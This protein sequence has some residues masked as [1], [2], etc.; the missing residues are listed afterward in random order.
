MAQHA[1]VVAPN[2]YTV[3]FENERVRLLQVTMAPGATSAQHSHPDYLVYALSDATVR[4]A[5]E[6]GQAGEVLIKK[7]DVLWRDAEVHSAE[8][9]GTVTFSGLFF[10]LK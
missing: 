3:I 1:A 7:G 2:V 4:L 9:T 8:N 6:S 5:D 10:E